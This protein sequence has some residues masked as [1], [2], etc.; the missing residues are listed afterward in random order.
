MRIDRATARRIAEAL[1]KVGL[2]GYETDGPEFELAVA[3]IMV[4]SAN[5]KRLPTPRAG[6]DTV[7]YPVG[8]W[9]GPGASGERARALAPAHQPPGR[10]KRG[11]GKR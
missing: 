4:A 9:I 6:F 7:G 5:S 11:K 3:T 2:W 10:T 8:T 1:F